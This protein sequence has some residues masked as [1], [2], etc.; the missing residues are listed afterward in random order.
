MTFMHKLGSF[1]HEMGLSSS[2]WV[3]SGLA[4]LLPSLTFFYV[5]HFCEMEFSQKYCGFI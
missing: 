2:N 3:L 4:W 5:L 1:N